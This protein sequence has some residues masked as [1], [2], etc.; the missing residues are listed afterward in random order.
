MFAQGKQHWKRQVNVV[1]TVLANAIATEPKRIVIT[2]AN[3]LFTPHNWGLKHEE[4]AKDS[5]L[6]V[7]KHLH[8][9]AKLVK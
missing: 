5:Y 3:N 1:F 8:Y 2:I 6:R 9:N 7:Q 4:S